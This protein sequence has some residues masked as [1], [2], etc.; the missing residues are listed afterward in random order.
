MSRNA[1]TGENEGRKYILL[2]K[3]RWGKRDRFRFRRGK[4]RVLAGFF[5]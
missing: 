4:I 1:G 5:L 3:R 2:A